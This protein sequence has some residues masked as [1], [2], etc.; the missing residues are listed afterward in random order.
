MVKSVDESKAIN[1]IRGSVIVVAGSG[2]CTGG[3]IKHHLVRN[4]DRAGSTILF[5]GYQA[6]GTLGRI[7]V[8]GADEVRILGQR[9][10]VRARVAQINGFS[11]HSDRDG[12]LRWL[13]ALEK[14][15]RQ[16]FVVHGEEDASKSFAEFVNG[17]TGWQVSV[18][19]YRD[20]V[21]LD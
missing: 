16:V 18:P 7:I 12:L 11:A 4:I 9:H 13:S 8:D 2:M 6:V 10:P 14:P 15:P 17:K 3:R 5:V 19:R 1:Q 21:I 20:E